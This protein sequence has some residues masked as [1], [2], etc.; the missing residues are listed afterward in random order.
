M[1][2]AAMASVVRWAL[3]AI[4]IAKIVRKS[5]RQYR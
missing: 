2:L 3:L 1:V 4:K 5:P